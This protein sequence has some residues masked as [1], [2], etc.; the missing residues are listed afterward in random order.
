MRFFFLYFPWQKSDLVSL[1]PHSIS[2]I[3]NCRVKRDIQNTRKKTKKNPK[4]K[5]AKTNRVP[6]KKGLELKE[7]HKQFWQNAEKYSFEL[8]HVRHYLERL[9]VTEQVKKLGNELFPN[10]KFDDVF[11]FSA[12]HQNNQGTNKQGSGKSDNLMDSKWYV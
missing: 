3:L 10:S 12:T 5:K 7:C 2:H 8:A 9:Q 6:S 11:I 4:P 1:S